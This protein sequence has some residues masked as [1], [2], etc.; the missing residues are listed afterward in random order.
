MNQIADGTTKLDNGGPG[1]AIGD[2]ISH[3]KESA[4][5]TPTLRKYQLHSA[6]V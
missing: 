4:V 1:G 2:Q 3:T 6:C 5:L